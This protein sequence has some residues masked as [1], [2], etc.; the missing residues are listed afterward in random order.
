MDQNLVHAIDHT[1]TSRHSVRAFL[2]T[3]V[4]TDTLKEI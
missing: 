2:N 3:P 4:S 1:I